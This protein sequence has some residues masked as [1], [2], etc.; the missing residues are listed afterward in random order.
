[1][2]KKPNVSQASAKAAKKSK[3]AQK[4]ERKEIKKVSKT[5]SSEGKSAASACGINKGKGK[6]S[7]KKR[8]DDSD[9][10]GEDLEGILER[11]SYRYG[12][13]SFCDI[14]VYVGCILH[15][16]SCKKNGRRHIQLLKNLSKVH[17]V[18]EQMPHSLRVRTETTFGASE[19]NSSVRMAEL[20]ARISTY[21]SFFDINIRQ[22][23]YNDVFRYTPEKH[24]WRKFVSP[25]CPGPRSAHAVVPSPIGGGK[26]FL[27]GGEYS[28]LHQNS[29]HHYRDFW[30]FD[31]G[32]HAWE[33]IETKIR[34]SARSG[35]R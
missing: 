17:Q 16:S 8:V 29:F 28:S 6:S 13:L 3:A 33:R 25:T 27:F 22:Y 35:H 7:K 32:S 30:C 4:V 23:F 24:E 20:Y 12:H 34:P 9:T 26:L 10:D 2:G 11:V 31:V 1:M 19:E 18:D 14:Q 21:L 5:K 15:T